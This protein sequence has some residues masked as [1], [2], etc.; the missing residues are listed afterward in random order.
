MYVCVIQT[1]TMAKNC[2]E[3][4]PGNPG[5]KLVL[6]NEAGLD[7]YHAKTFFIHQPDVEG[8]EL[9]RRYLVYDIRYRDG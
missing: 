4:R 1:S 9:I 3:Q 2:L 6:R 7:T 5:M 8:L